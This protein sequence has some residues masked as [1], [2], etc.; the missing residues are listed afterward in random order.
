MDAK[1]ENLRSLEL[2]SKIHIIIEKKVHSKAEKVSFRRPIF[3][4]NRDFFKGKGDHRLVESK[5]K[6]EYINDI[7]KNRQEEVVSN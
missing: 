1:L 6:L 5:K 2:Q 7:L 3:E 4:T